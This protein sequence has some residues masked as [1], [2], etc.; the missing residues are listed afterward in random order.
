MRGRCW[1]S[2]C[3]ARVLLYAIQ[4]LQALLPFNP[5]GFTAGNVS[6]DLAFNTAAS[7]DTN[8]NWQN[9]APET[10][11]SYF[12]QMAAL[13]VQNF[14][15]AA[16]GL[17]SPWRWCADSRGRR[18]ETWAISGW[19]D[20]GDVYILLPISIVGALCLCS[21]GVIQNLKP[22]TAAATVEGAKQ[23]S[24]RG[25]WH[26]RK[27]IKMLGTNGGG[28]FNANSA[29]PFENP[30]PFTNMFANVADFRHP[31]GADVHVRQDGARYA[32]GLGDLRGML[33]DVPRGRLGVLS[34][35][36]SRA[37]R[38]WPRPVLRPRPTP[39]KPGGNM[40]G[41]ES[42]SAL[43]TRRCSPR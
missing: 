25:R 6:P 40:E 34:A 43:P 21:Q 4:R 23:T 41:K 31:G 22:Y 19:T 8:T 15:S 27:S 2:V 9:Y 3:S 5:Q 18:Q 32:P 37:I 29:H 28:F 36:S 42:G 14:A 17:P 30:T 24:R 26:R 1:P 35:S 13:T 7:F 16:A 38:C 39:G 11:L 20:A 10:T 33:G 12:V